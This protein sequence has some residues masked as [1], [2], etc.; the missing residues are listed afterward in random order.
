MTPGVVAR[1]LLA[2]LPIDSYRTGK[3][4]RAFLSERLTAG[5]IAA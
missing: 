5:R 3:L 2:A 1:V 4:G